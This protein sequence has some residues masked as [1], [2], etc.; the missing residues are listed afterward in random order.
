M[1]R[2]VGIEPSQLRANTRNRPRAQS[3]PDQRGKAGLASM[4]RSTN[5]SVAMSALDS[6]RSC[7][8]DPPPSRESAGFDAERKQELGQFLTPV[9]IG[10]FMAS[11]FEAHP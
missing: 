1:S 3:H 7:I 8:L 11:L 4:G 10:S 2:R 5:L 6:S 9:A